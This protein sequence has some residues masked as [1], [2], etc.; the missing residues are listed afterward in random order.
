MI[1]LV[2]LMGF[3]VF[4]S[5]E[6]F[7]SRYLSHH[8]HDHKKNDDHEEEGRGFLWSLRNK[9]QA[10]GWLNLLADSMHNFTDGIALG[11]S[12]ASGSGLALPTFLS[13]I[14]HEIP[15][16]IGDFT[17][18]MQSGFSKFEAIRAQFLT[19]IAAMAGTAVGLYAQRN[20]T[21]EELLLAF[22]SGGF[23]YIA[24]VSMLPSIVTDKNSPISQTVLEILAFS[25]GVGVMLLVAL[26]E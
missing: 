12:F 18:L 8:C 22:T 15:H 26:F 20:K 6:K 25:L 9:L 3:L 5:A 2:L 24:T 21:A 13:V 17:I 14:L 1:P 16:E 10:A 7:A 19:A 11:A 4:L 23:L